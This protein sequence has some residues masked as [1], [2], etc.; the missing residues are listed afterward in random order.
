LFVTRFWYI[1]EV[2][3]KTKTVTGMTRDGTFIVEKGEIKRPVKNLRFNQSLLELLSN[4]E[5][6]SEPVRNS[7][8]F[9]GASMV[10]P[11]VLAKNF[12][13]TSASIF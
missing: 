2:E 5:E 11:G 1:R 9:P 7:G 4:V 8:N 6:V 3:P 12:N 13:F 10:N